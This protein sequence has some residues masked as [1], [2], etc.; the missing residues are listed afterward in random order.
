[1]VYLRGCIPIPDD[2]GWPPGYFLVLREKLKVTP[3]PAGGSF[4]T[5]YDI[6]S[7]LSVQYAREVGR[8]YSK[9]VKLIPET[10]AN[11]RWDLRVELQ[12]DGQRLHK[13]Y[14]NLL[15]LV[16]CKTKYGPSG[17]LLQRPRKVCQEDLAEYEGNH[18]D[19][20]NLD[21]RLRNI[22]LLPKF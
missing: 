8:A 6:C 12:A 10:D 18:R 3:C 19:W 11:G 5:E 20:N 14:H 17:R 9:G 13:Q 1:M 4:L 22:E 7:E 16:A 21:C 15:A 2:F